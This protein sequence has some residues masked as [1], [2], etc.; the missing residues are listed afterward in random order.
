MIAVGRARSFARV[1]VGAVVGALLLA[2]AAIQLASDSLN[3]AAAANG[4]LPARIPIAYGVAVYRALDRIAP[5]AYVEASLAGYEL[6]TGDPDAALRHALQLPPS[7]VRDELL[8]RT[9]AARGDRALA[10]EYDLAAPDVEA[11]QRVVGA[12]L[13]GHPA[14]AYALERALNVRLSLLSTHPDAV[15][16][17]SWR[18]GELANRTAWRQVPGSPAQIAWLKIGMR[19]FQAAADLA[20]LSG[21][22]AIAAANQAVQLGDL[23]RGARLFAR[24]VAADPASADAV[25]GLGVVAFRRGDRAGARAD[26]QRARKLDPNALM[27]RALERDLR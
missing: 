3:A 19:H 22:Y 12:L 20:P 5:A 8:A 11:V 9:A 27:V 16:E 21:K 26:L 10:L 4:S 2:F 15:A 13:P 23:G 25:A 14:Q 24:A 18:M 1:A 6:S 7:P 17:T